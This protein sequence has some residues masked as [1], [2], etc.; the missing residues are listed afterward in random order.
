MTRILGAVLT[1]G[2]CAWMGDR[3]AGQLKKRVDTIDSLIT[4]FLTLERELS[5]C[6]TPLHGLMERMAE[7]TKPPV[8]SVFQGAKK[9][10]E[11]LE[12]EEFSAAWVRLAEEIPD[13]EQEDRRIVSGLGVVLGRYDGHRQGEAIARVCRELE[14]NRE[15]AEQN[16]RRM[17][18]VY[19]TVGAVCGGFLLILLL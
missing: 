1:A 19:R 7:C 18:R 12:E 14:R 5:D 13:L 2:V 3:R 8:R 17:G 16:F 4:A 11:R 10:L 9:A 6:L 15:H